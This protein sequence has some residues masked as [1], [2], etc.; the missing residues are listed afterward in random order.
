MSTADELHH[1]LC[2]LQGIAAP[3]ARRG[4]VLFLR[5]DDPGRPSYLDVAIDG[6]ATERALSAVLADKLARYLWGRWQFQRIRERLSDAPQ[7]LSKDEIEYTAG[8]AYR[9]IQCGAYPAG[10]GTSTSLART[11]ARLYSLLTETHQIDLGGFLRFRCRELTQGIEE[12]VRDSI[13]DFLIHREYDQFVDVLRYF[14]NTTPVR[15]G[16]VYVVCKSGRAFGLEENYRPLDVGLV[17]QVARSAHA[18]DLHPQDVLVSALI[19]RS[20][21]RLVIAT[22]DPG[23]VLVQTLA[24]VFAGRAEV[25]TDGPECDHLMAT[26]DNGQPPHYTSI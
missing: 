12:A 11:A 5:V 3:L 21:E 4:H 1:L 9:R 20:P 15:P 18:Q 23:T 10:G 25:W 7:D 14:L 22:R 17:E 2:W 6:C 8:A 16:T 26:I 13:D 19:T 24:R